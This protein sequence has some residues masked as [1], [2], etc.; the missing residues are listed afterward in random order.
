MWCEGRIQLHYF[1]CGY[2]VTPAL[3]LEKTFFSI[4]LSWYS[5]PKIPVSF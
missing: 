5:C 2:P 4:E 3:F 1:A